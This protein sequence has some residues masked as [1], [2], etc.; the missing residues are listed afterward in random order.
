MIADYDD[1]TPLTFAERIAGAEA[2]ESIAA[3]MVRS[4]CATFGEWLERGR[5]GRI[6]DDQ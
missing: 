1:D 6:E 3:A 2:A 4:G 5:P